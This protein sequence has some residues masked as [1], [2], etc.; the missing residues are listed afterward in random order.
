MGV[1][2]TLLFNVS[3]GSGVALFE[4]FAG[5]K[6]FLPYC[7]DPSFI[8]R[9]STVLKMPVGWTQG[10]QELERGRRLLRS[11]VK[12]GLSKAFGCSASISRS[13]KKTRFQNRIGNGGIRNRFW[14]A[15]G[16]RHLWLDFPTNYRAN[17]IIQAR[18]GRTQEA[19]RLG[20][21]LSELF[22]GGEERRPLGG[23][24]RLRGMPECAEV[25]EHALR[26]EGQ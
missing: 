18:Q 8:R 23:L 4:K 6:P 19:S 10:S 1:Y 24:P 2:P 26:G 14:A 16:G 12:E 25:A 5:T 17:P 3:F 9:Q 15:L 7:R 13:G 21:D 20:V 22:G 11:L